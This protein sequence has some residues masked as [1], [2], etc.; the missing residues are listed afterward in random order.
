MEISSQLD[1]TK[2]LK[3]CLTKTQKY[4]D[5]KIEKITKL[6]ARLEAEERAVKQYISQERQLTEQLQ[7]VA[8]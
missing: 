3:S 6:Q 8:Y 2:T 7:M 1:N 5:Q 4:I